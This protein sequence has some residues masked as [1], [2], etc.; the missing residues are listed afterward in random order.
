MRRLGYRWRIGELEE[1]FRFWTMTL[2]MFLTLA[3][4]LAVAAQVIL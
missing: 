4:L 1:A 3:F 2:L